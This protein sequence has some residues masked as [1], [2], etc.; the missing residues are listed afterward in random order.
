MYHIELRQFPHS[1]WR[2]NLS[3]QELQAVVEPWAREQIV[4]VGERK[5]SPHQAKLVILDGPRLEIAQLSMGRGWRT[6]QRNSEDVTERLLA[7]GRQA[8]EAAQ[9]EQEASRVSAAIAAS[10]AGAA[11]TGAPESGALGDP[12]A[13]GVQLATLLGADAMA[14]LD[15]W[16]AAAAGT[17][18]LAPSESLAVAE[19]SLGSASVDQ[20]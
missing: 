5:W 19:Q 8:A 18:G 17:P 4:E 9:A 10:A 20:G 3:E 14:L 2:F 16:R 1:A 11:A 15:A 7:L 13:L 12:I 6:A